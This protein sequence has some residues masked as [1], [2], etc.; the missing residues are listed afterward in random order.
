MKMSKNDLKNELIQKYKS[1]TDSEFKI[2][3]ISYSS[4]IDT[5]KHLAPTILGGSHQQV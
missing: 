2:S 4:P 5:I 1:K 3:K